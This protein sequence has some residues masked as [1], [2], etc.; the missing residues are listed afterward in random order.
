MRKLKMINNKVMKNQKG[1]VLLWTMLAI[2][3]YFLCVSAVTAVII[4]EIR[5]SSEIDSSTQAY[6]AAE[7]GMERV[8]NYIANSIDTAGKKS[9]NPVDSTSSATYDFQVFKVGKVGG[10]DSQPLPWDPSRNCSTTRLGEYVYCYYSQGEA[11]DIA[12]RIEGSQS[13]IPLTQGN[14]ISF[15][16][17]NVALTNV[18]GYSNQFINLSKDYQGIGFYLPPGASAY[19]FSG[20]INPVSGSFQT[21]LAEG[22]SNN[23][24]IGLDIEDKKIY[25]E[26]MALGS[27]LPP[28]LPSTYIDTSTGTGPF[29]FIL[30][31]RPGSTTSLKVVDDNGNGTCI[32]VVT[33]DNSPAITPNYA[34]YPQSSSIDRGGAG[35]LT[36][37]SGTDTLIENVGL[38]LRW[39]Q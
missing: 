17:N 1:T 33:L 22:D 38:F 10:T 23:N 11:G 9:N 12:R 16:D 36:M 32:G 34:F 35:Q 21:G 27:A 2:G 24:A 25:L 7:A 15:N 8:N 29:Q 26:Q 39:Q 20:Y 3:L 30:T 4:T 6:M 37:T 5:Q 14:S 18:P 31:Y 19:T 13:D 28:A